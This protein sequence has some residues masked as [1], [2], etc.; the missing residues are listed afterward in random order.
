M[1]N[2]IKLSVKLIGGF[3]IAG[4][5]TLIVG[6]LGWY[7]IRSQTEISRQTN[8]FES[9]NK[10]LLNREIDHLNWAM[11]VGQF[12]RDENMKELN[13][14]KDAHRCAFGKWYYSDEKI[15]TENDIP[16]IKEL[17]RQIEEPHNKLHAS[18][19][20]LEK[21]LQK[22][23]VFRQEALT[24]YG[25]ETSRQLE[26]VQGLL[27]EIRPQVG[28][29]IDLHLKDAEKKSTRIALFSLIIMVTGTFLAVIMGIFLSRS[30]TRP[31]HR[32]VT[33][34]AEGAEQVASASGQV[35]SSSQSLAEGTSEQAASIEE[36]SSSLEEMSSMTKQNADNSARADLLMKE[37]QEVVS[38]AN[39]SMSRLT[40]SMDEISK[41]SEETS[42]II[43]TIDEIAFQTNLL[44]LN[45]AVEAA[46]AGEAGA[47]FAVVAD[48]VRN[49]AMRASEAAKNTATLIEGTVKK[50]KDGTHLVAGT[51]EAFSGVTRNT[52][53]VGNLVAEI[54][55]AS[56]EQSQGIDQ[57]NKAI[58]E[59][60][61]VVQ[62]NAAHAEESASASE[63]MNAQAEQIKAHVDELMKVIG[64]NSNRRTLTQWK[65]EKPVFSTR[66]ERKEISGMI[67]GP[68]FKISSSKMP[69]KR[70]RQMTPEQVIPMDED[71]L[72]DF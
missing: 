8:H 20:D 35:A 14:E 10:Q 1:M 42:K 66:P 36:T 59:M 37:T 22:G 39:D 53:D 45:A 46:R 52:V 7:G 55:A 3:L 62:Q 12:Q 43:K 67:P 60:D 61:K 28:Q 72:K 48:E 6:A 5:V 31:I 24:L 56:I 71:D 41:A 2:K 64:E 49:L 50:V 29:Y 21:I 40:K 4:A 32:V 33:G 16:A 23:Q 34:L 65:T 38:T 57:I 70:T 68:A 30:I 9:I 11:K 54:T 69:V 13:V 47:G 17:L 27:S 25:T 26:R 44:A 15:K 58:A 51:N 19:T 63:E 18:A